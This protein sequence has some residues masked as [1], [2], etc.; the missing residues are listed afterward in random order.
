MQKLS[1]LPDSPSLAQAG[2]PD[3]LVTF[4]VMRR[5]MGTDMQHHGT[6]KDAHGALRQDHGRHLHTVSGSECG[7]AV[8]SRT[9]AVFGDWKLRSKDWDEGRNIRSADVEEQQCPNCNL[10]K[11]DEIQTG[12]I[13]KCL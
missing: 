11:F 7:A 6:L 8:S 5:T 12:G 4:Q 3:R 9:I 10:T 2:I 1:A 13:W